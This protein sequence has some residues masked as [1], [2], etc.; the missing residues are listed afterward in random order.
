[1]LIPT[2]QALPHTNK[3]P[4]HFGHSTSYHLTTEQRN[5]AIQ[6]VDLLGEVLA[7]LQ[8]GALPA[9]HQGHLGPR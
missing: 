2:V 1:M 5:A 9:A 7:L 3:A 4:F 8:R 6:V